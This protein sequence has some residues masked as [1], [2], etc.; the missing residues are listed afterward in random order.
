MAKFKF[1]MESILNL[2]CRIAEQKEQ[3]FAKALAIVAQEKALLE[4]YI[5][6]KKLTIA[7]LKG[8]ID[9]K[10]SPIDFKHLNN[11]IEHSKVNI[12]KQKEV[13]VKAEIFAEKKRQE[14]IEA[15]KERKMLDK[16]KE[17]RYEEHIEEEK[18]DEQ[19]QVDEV[20][21][22]RFKKASSTN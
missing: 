15:T 12:A 22:Y 10:I 17:N 8:E 6:D 18:R 11:F 19:K 7:K 13:I 14:L 1:E 5:N 4:K 16:L 2:K 20:V 9:I 21:S 3:E